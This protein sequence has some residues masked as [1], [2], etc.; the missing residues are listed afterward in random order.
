MLTARLSRSRASV[1]Q[2]RYPV[3]IDKFLTKVFGSSNQRYLKGLQPTIDRI[4][5]LEATVKPLSDDEMRSRIAKLREQIAQAVAEED[6]KEARKRR[7][8][9]ALN[10]ILPEVFA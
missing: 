5:E 1:L 10:E 2:G 8:Q 7:E 6:D 9:E 3:M 4:N